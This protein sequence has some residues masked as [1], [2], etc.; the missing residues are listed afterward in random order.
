MLKQAIPVLHIT[1]STVTEDFF[2]NRL[3]FRVEFANRPTANPD[4]CY[5]GF[6]RDVARFHASSHAE[7]SV[8]GCAVFVIVDDVYALHNEFVAKG[9]A[10]HLKPTD[11][12]WGNREVY[13]RDPD[14]NSIRFIQVLR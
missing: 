8:S 7:D 11:Q 10:I 3:G 2:C 9:V 13:V 14:G 12:T 5:M 1:R 6:V 4:P